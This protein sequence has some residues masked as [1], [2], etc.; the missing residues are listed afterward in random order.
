LKNI[1]SQSSSLTR[2]IHD[3]RGI[4][5]V[6]VLIA[7]VMLAL[8]AYTFS[9]MMRAEHSGAQIYGDLAQSQVLV[10]SAV[11]QVQALLLLP[12]ES[13]SQMGGSYDNPALFQNRVVTSTA[14]GDPMSGMFV[15]VAPTTDDYGNANGV[16]FGLENESAKLNL[17]GILRFDPP[18]NNA[19]ATSP[20]P[21]G[22][23]T[24]GNNTGRTGGNNTGGNNTGGNNTGGNNT[25]GNNTG[26]NNTGG[27]STGGNNT[28]GN[29]NTGGT[30]GG[31][32]E[33]EAELEQVT[34]QD[35]LMALPG[36]TMDIADAILDWIDED[37]EPREFGAERDF[38]SS[39]NS[40]YQARNGPINSIEELLLVRGVTPE[41]LFG[42]DQNRNGM[43]DP[44]EM[45]VALPVD[46]T[47]G[48][49]DFG[50]AQYLTVYSRETFKDP[51][52][53]PKI[54]LNGDDLQ[55]LFTELSAVID[56]DWAGFICAYR[57]VGP[58][59]DPEGT[60]EGEQNPGEPIA[61]RQLDLSQSGRTQL[62]S[63][64]DLVGARVQ[65]TFS[66]EGEQGEPVVLASPFPDDPTSLLT[67]LNQLL[68]YTTVETEEV[69][70]GRVNVNL[71][72]R[73]VLRAVPGM[74]EDV[75]NSLIGQRS[76]ATDV[77]NDTKRYP[78]WLYT[79]QIVTD[80]DTMRQMMPFLTTGGDVF[81]AQV[82]GYFD[83]A[84]ATSR[85]E[86][87]I[88]GTRLQVPVVLWRDMSSLGRGFDPTWFQPVSP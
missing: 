46:E 69:I 70:P 87:V 10:E 9:D 86:V 64:L 30:G 61:G 19:G 77:V 39:L 14:Q 33:G 50:W 4:V 5:L 65:V 75:V 3:H 59:Q 15:I 57:Q 25:G 85:A 1:M 2:R 63:V 54:N 26:G 51:T 88:D 58:Y 41:L 29:N 84:G 13:R 72:P 34:A 8:S 38:Y 71:A 12:P 55:L 24:G 7:V 36:M 67:S 81:R 82:F 44:E 23:N 37:E 68:D 48:S 83:E 20:A 62:Q 42:R 27:N 22:N 49:M 79:E 43:I 45:Q 74:T 53:N 21:S 60:P 56:A 6:I 40:P 32:D 76:P 16:R 78:I 47:L 80:L 31:G 35:A 11:A 73:P 28:G 17:N 18:D 66:S 52:G